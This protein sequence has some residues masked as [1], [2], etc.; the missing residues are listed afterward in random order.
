MPDLQARQEAQLDRLPGDR[1]RARYRRLRRDDRRECGQQHQ[2]PEQRVGHDLKE[3]VEAGNV[4]GPRVVDDPD[5]LAKVVQHQR[6]Q[7]ECEPPEPDRVG[8]E[9]PTVGVQGLGAR[10]RQ[11][12]ATEH[13]VGI[14][15]VVDEESNRPGRRQCLEHGGVS[16]DLAE[17]EHRDHAEPD[18]HHGA[19]Q[20]ADRARAEALENEQPD[21]DA[22]PTAAPLCG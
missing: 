13:Q 1:E 6:G 11:Y 14:C 2:R 18:E 4:R 22:R 7:H 17:S 20:P 15:T 16:D 3:G 19:E 10:D 12:D 5:A 8:A 9:V 21:Q